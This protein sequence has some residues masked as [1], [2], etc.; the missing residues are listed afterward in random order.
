MSNIEMHLNDYLANDVKMEPIRQG[1]G[2]GL[3]KAGELDENVVGLCADLTESVHF[4][5]FKEAFP[6]RFF[7]VGIAEQNLVTVGAGLAAQGKVPFVGSY[8]VFSPG[9]NWE[10]IRTTVCLNNRPVKIIGGHAGV[11]TGEDGATHQMLEDIALMRVLPNMVILAPGDSIEAE[12]ATLAAASDKR[13]CYIR[14]ARPA[15]P[16]FTTDKTPFEIGKAYVLNKGQD[17]TIISTGTMTFPALIT[18]EKLFKEGVDAEIIHV[19][20]IKP[21]DGVTIL[22]SASKTK[23]VLTVEEA[24][25]IGGLGGAVAE[26]L[27]EELPTPLKRMGMHDRFGTSGHPDELFEYFGLTSKHIMRAAHQL[28]TSIGKE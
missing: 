19:P 12:K 18:A 28:L 8:A 17:L 26:L 21:L 4:H 23:A 3:K 11:C 14:L 27:S 6:E 9:R 10:Q 2:L 25:V 13:P 1:F 20:T 15:L 16:I 24:Q 5:L 7:E 22:Q